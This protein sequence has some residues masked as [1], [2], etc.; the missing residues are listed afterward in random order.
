MVMNIFVVVI[1]RDDLL[2]FE[3]FVEV[4]IK[5]LLYKRKFVYL[6]L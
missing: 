5:Y 2:F 6:K 1:L 4:F 3:V